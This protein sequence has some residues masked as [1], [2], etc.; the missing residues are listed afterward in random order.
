MPNCL[1]HVSGVEKNSCITPNYFSHNIFLILSSVFSALIN[2]RA[3]CYYDFYT[4][5][6]TNHLVVFG[7]MISLK[8]INTKSLCVFGAMISLKR[9]DTKS[10][11]GVWHFVFYKNDTESDRLSCVNCGKKSHFT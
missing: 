10:F 1:V 4:K 7:A 6:D 5:I 11:S 8:R 9:I 2:F 3:W